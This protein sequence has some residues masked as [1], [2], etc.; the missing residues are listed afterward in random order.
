MYYN[1]TLFS[2]FA[3]QIRLIMSNTRSGEMV[4]P[5]I[6]KMGTITGLT[7]TN[8]K[9]PDGNSFQIKNDSF[10][11]VTLE[12]KLASM[13]DNDDFVATSFAVGW[14]PEIVREIKANASHTNVSL[15]WGY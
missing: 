5:Q 9:L 15:K 10:A 4:S 12:V 7:T 6:A 13:S 11:P 2:K 1:N 8:F 3:Q 14:N